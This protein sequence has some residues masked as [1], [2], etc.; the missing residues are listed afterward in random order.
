MNERGCKQ[1]GMSLSVFNE[2]GRLGCAECYTAFQKELIPVF[3]H[4][5][6]NDFHIGKVPIPD[7]AELEVHRALISLRRELEQAVNREEFEQ[8]A[9][10]RDRIQDIEH[11]KEPD[12]MVQR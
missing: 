1:C 10:L 9:L 12:P 6:G 3:K 5:H 7:P 11:K 8:A 2:T 4:V